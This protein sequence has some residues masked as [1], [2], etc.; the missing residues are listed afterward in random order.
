MKVFFSVLPF[1]VLVILGCGVWV[2]V[3]RPRSVVPAAL[4]VTAVVVVLVGLS[5]VLPGPSQGM[6]RLLTVLPALGF[7]VVL[8]LGVVLLR[9]RRTR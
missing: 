7:L 2:V 3:R 6:D 9:R 8:W 5:F 4:I 1:L